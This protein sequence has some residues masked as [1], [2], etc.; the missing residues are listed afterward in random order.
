MGLRLFEV[1]VFVAEEV[2]D[3][4]ESD[5]GDG[6]L[7]GLF[8]FGFGVESDAQ[9]GSGDHWQVVGAIAHGYCLLDVHMLYLR[10]QF[11]QLC[12]ASSIDDL[13]HVATGEFPVDDLK[14]VG[15]Y[16]VDAKFML[17]VVAEEGESS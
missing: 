5:G 10:D 11:E 7:G 13:A 3:A 17:K 15:I 6:L 2:E 16:I 12:F 4:I 14:F 9:T 1:G 8:H